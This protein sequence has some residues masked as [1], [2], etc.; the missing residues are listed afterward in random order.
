MIKGLLIS[1]FAVFIA[2]AAHS[3]GK[4]PCEPIPAEA[5]VHRAVASAPVAKITVTTNVQKSDLVLHLYCIGGGDGGK[6]WHVTG[7]SE[8]ADLKPG[9][10][11][12]VIAE[13]TSKYCF[14]KVDL[15]ITPSL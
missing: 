9:K 11:V 3:Q 6:K 10:Y 12:L 15:E 4:S 7:V 8:F 13:K 5:S 14:K 1:A 2:L